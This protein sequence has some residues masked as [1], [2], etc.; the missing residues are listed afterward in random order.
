MSGARRKAGVLALVLAA[1]S[2]TS[3]PAPQSVCEAWK[4]VDA[5]ADLKGW[6]T[7]AF[8]QENGHVWF[9]GSSSSRFKVLI[10]DWNGSS[11]MVLPTPDLPTRTNWLAGIAG[12]AS[13][14]VWAT[15]AAFPGGSDRASQPIALHWDGESWSDWSLP[16]LPGTQGG[17]GSIAVVASDDVWSVGSFGE[18]GSHRSLI[19]H[20]DG[21]NWTVSPSPHD[22]EHYAHLSSIS[23]VSGDDVW[24]A[25]YDQGGGPFRNL[26]LHWDGK[27]WQ[28]VDVPVLM[29]PLPGTTGTP[30]VVQGVVALSH[31]DVWVG[32]NAQSWV[33]RANGEGL[34]STPFFVH[35]DGRSW[36]GARG[37]VPIESSVELYAM[38][39]SP[40]G[41]LLAV[42]SVQNGGT[43]MEPIIY[44]WEERAWVIDPS[45]SIPPAPLHMDDPRT[46]Q[47]VSVS[48]APTGEAYALGTYFTAANAGN[49]LLIE[50]CSPRVS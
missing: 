24:A 11:W 35:W 32:A 14:D 13:D 4:R 47:L 12:A 36:S 34:G 22:G 8:I 25:G 30:P 3:H 17:L 2:C 42:G 48:V 49:L 23:A 50:R 19:E 7:T 16:L 41:G 27:R 44:R 21:E 28:R 38:A 6:L 43:V 40:T 18:K 20:W 46:N 26:L 9:V 1:G 37:P 5:P 29:K 10:M 45:P 31:A 15:G 39:G 33:K